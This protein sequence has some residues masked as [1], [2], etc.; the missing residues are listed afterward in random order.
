VG[1]ARQFFCLP[2]EGERLELVIGDGAEYMQ[3]QQRRADVIMVDGYDAESQVAE[4]STAE[5]YRDCARVLGTT[6]MLV[7]NLWG[8]DREFSN[9]IERMA[10]AFDGLVACLPAGRP[11]NIVA[12]AFRRSPGQPSWSELMRRARELENKYGLEFPQFV[13]GLAAMNPHDAERLLF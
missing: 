1:I 4:L 10:Q 8:G 7:V 9:C 11:G 5:F 2:P 6:G 13:Q 3:G 12:L